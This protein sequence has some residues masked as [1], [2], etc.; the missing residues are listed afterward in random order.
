MSYTF[1]VKENSNIKQKQKETGLEIQS[2][3]SR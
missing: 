2:S 1:K 3:L